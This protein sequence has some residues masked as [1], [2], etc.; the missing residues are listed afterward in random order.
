MRKNSQVKEKLLDKSLLFAFTFSILFLFQNCSQDN[1]AEKSEEST[2]KETPVVEKL[3]LMGYSKDRIKEYDKF[4]LVEGDLMFS[5]DIKD[6]NS[7]IDATSRHASTNNLVAQNKVTFMSVYMDSSIPTS[8]VDNWRDALNYAVGDLNNISG[9]KVHFNIISSGPADIVIKSD[10]NTL[11]DNVLAMAGFPSN[12]NPF[13]LIQIN[14]DFW[15]DI[16]VSEAGKRYNLVHELGHCIGL[17]HTNWDDPN[18]YEGVGSY[19]ANYIP[20]TPTQDPNSVMNGGTAL[21]TWN[22][23]SQY[24]LTAIR[25]LYP[26]D[27]VIVQQVTISGPTYIAGGTNLF[28]WTYTGSLPNADLDSI[29][30][31]YYKSNNGGQ[32]AY[33]IAW[34]ATGNFMTVADTYYSD[35]GNQTSNFNIYITI[36]DTNGNLYKS[37]TYSIMKKGKFKLEGAL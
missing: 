18:R 32:G 17:R 14:L 29:M 8:G 22:G 4:Y 7:K 5:K 9:S 3:I 13:N 19:G 11:N 37:P 27:P 10:N 25:Y 30:W 6:Y 34:G 31:W 1:P 20:N 15:S 35:T 28:N 26:T 21:N 36:R 24:D 12:N 16:T 33:V 2:L 23:F